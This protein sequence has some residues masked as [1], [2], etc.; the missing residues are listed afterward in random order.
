M[1]RVRYVNRLL[2]NQIALAC[3]FFISCTRIFGDTRGVY[4]VPLQSKKF[5]T[6]ANE[7]AEMW[8]LLQNETYTFK[9][10][11]ASFNIPRD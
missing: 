8:K 1:S 11:S 4:K 10:F 3:F 9:F 2:L 5:V 6:E 7:K